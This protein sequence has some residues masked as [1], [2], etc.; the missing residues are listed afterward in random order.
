M[1]AAASGTHAR[2]LALM[3]PGQGSQF[4]GMAAELIAQSP[5]ARD[6][7]AQADEIMG[8]PLSKIMAGDQGDEL[9][10]TVHTQPAVFVHSMA[11]LELLRDCCPISP[12]I[13]AG[14]SLGEYTALC[15]AGVL[16]FQEA[17]EIIKVRASSMDQAQPQGTCAMAAI[18]GLTRQEVLALVDEHRGGEVLEAAN[19]NAPDQIVISGHVEAVNRAAE[20]AKKGRRTRAVVLP[21]SSAFH[22]QLMGPAGDALAE[23][24]QR[25]TTG[26]GAFP[27]LANVNAQPYPAGESSVQD[28][29][30][31]QVVNPVL[32]EE[33]VGAMLSAKPDIFVEI[34]PGKVL[35][36][37]LKRIDRSA[38]GVNLDS[39][40]SIQ[41]FAEG[42]A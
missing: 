38:V 42:S 33:C 20:A 31:R 6:I 7:I 1:N 25:V 15:A 19:F 4:Q 11:L 12:V 22:T 2:S 28:L 29:L 34:G 41:A 13:A 36:G 18:V 37:L 27:V 26:P 40:E 14:H 16:S 39:L 30:T 8:Y 10:R 24:L 9:N 5:R 3:F 32:W 23:R 17:L 21:V 35:T